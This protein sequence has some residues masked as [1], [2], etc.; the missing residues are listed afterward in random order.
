MAYA[1]HVSKTAESVMTQQHAKLALVDISW[2]LIKIKYKVVF[3]VKVDVLNVQ[4]LLLAVNVIPD[5]LWTKQQWIAKVAPKIVGNVQ[6]R[7]CVRDV[8]WELNWLIMLVLESSK[9]A[10][11]WVPNKPVPN[12]TKA[13]SW[14]PMP[15]NAHKSRLIHRK[16]N[17]LTVVARIP[18]MW[19]IIV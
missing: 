19:T 9:T 1:Q 13:T 3:Y 8:W 16:T 18:T 15:T 11:A 7:M 14:A 4:I 10:P 6:Q 12:A 17:Q 5:I 2:A